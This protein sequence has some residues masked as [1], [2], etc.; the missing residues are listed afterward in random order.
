M[1][2]A[3]VADLDGATALGMGTAYW[4][5][6]MPD[7]LAILSRGG[8]RTFAELDARANGVAQALRDAGLHPGD[9]VA[10][11]CPNRPEFVEVFLAAQRA[12][13]VL[14]PINWHARP[15]EVAYIVADS[16]AKAFV[17][18]AHFADTAVRAAEGAPGLRVRWS[19]GN[20]V[21]G[22]ARFESAVRPIAH[23]DFRD[24][25]LGDTMLYT[26]GTTGRPKGVR[27]AKPDPARAVLGW[28]IL[29]SV[30]G[31]RP[32]ESDVALATGPLYHAGPIHLCLSIPLGHGIPTVLID[33]WD[34]EEMLARIEEH[35]VTHTYCVPTMFRRLLSLPD[36]VRRRYDVSSLRFVIHGA[37]PCPPEDKRA[38]IEWWGPILTEIYAA[39][40]GMGTMVSSQEWLARPGTVGRPMPGQIQILDEHGAPLPPGEVGTVFLKPV[41]GASFEYFGDEEKTRS[42]RQQDLFT[43]GDMGYL[44]DEGYLFLT[45]RSAEIVITGGSNV[46]PAEIDAVLIRHPDVHD[47]AA[48]GIPDPEWG[49]VLLAVVALAPG[50]ESGPE[51][52]ASILAHCRTELPTFKVPRRVDF[53]NEVPR[54][55]AGK[56][57]RQRLRDH[58]RARMP[59]LAVS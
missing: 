43:V 11:L 44:D 24:P 22:F 45:G 38:M 2:D 30:F 7:R 48:V 14:T 19:I 32:G 36:T 25:E 34:A 52:E 15:D 39:T 53:V 17:T 49:E 8:N 37:A 18:D 9:G 50:V 13:F 5:E 40:E 59:T 4:A 1:K 16:R 47:A 46:Y 12:G 21:P 3:R 28:K 57:Y 56:V 41:A 29:A 27:R 6:R 42:T 35:R 26:S 31:F 23:P 55:E 20:D 10:L 54:S 51:A 58:Y 33:R